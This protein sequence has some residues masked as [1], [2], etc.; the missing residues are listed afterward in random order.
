LLARVVMSASNPGDLVLDPFF[1][2]GTTGAVA[3][4]FGRSLHRLRARTD[5][6]RRGA[7]AHRRG[8]AP[9]ARGHFDRADEAQRTARRLR[10]CGRGRSDRAGCRVVRREAP[11]HAAIV[12][13]DG[14]LAL[15]DIV[16][17]IHKIGALAQ[18]LP[19]C[20]G[21]TFWRFER[22]GAPV[23]IDELRAEMRRRMKAD[24]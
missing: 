15:G 16:G 14:S 10:R 1:G 19:A 5:L 24:A 13:A 22:D 2:S 8:R 23:C 7:G 21:W 20:N 4:R 9:A 3:K 12:R 6:C 17:S 11:L 18:G